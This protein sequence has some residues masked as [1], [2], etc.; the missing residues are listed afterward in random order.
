[1]KEKME[2]TVAEIGTF[3]DP[4]SIKARTNV[5]IFT[6]ASREKIGAAAT[7]QKKKK[8]R[9]K[10]EGFFKS[11]VSSNFNSVKDTQTRNKLAGNTGNLASKNYLAFHHEESS[12]S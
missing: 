9:S 2:Y 8:G 10:I 4:D 5:Q 3:M 7:I 11:D 1:M 6:K 12:Q